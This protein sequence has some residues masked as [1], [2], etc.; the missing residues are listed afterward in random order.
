MIACHAQTNVEV[1]LIVWKGIAQYDL[2]FALLSQIDHP[3]Q[4]IRRRI[5]IPGQ[6]N[7]RYRIDHILFFRLAFLQIGIDRF[8]RH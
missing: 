7:F 5:V 2:D 3:F 1:T 6:H 4:R 8:N